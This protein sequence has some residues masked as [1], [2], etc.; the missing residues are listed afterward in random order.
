MKFFRSLFL[1]VGLAALPAC[2]TSEVADAGKPCELTTAIQ[3]QAA[4]PAPVPVA[5]PAP[6]PAA[7]HSFVVHFDFDSA[8]IRASAMQILYEASQVAGKVK[9]TAIRI[10]GFTDA[11]GKSSYNQHLSERRAQAVADQFNK[12]GVK[13]T[14]VETKGFGKANAVTKSKGKSKDNRRVEIVFEGG[15]TAELPADTIKTASADAHAATTTKAY[16]ASVAAVTAPTRDF[17][18]SLPLQ[19]AVKHAIKRDRVQ[20]GTA[21]IPPASAIMGSPSWMGGRAV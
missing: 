7:P 2:A 16:P 9:P 3:A 5:I 18:P 6:A 13:V 1:L 15:D 17:S 11:S 20:I 21:W 4:A 12:L 14:V 19:T 10:H 8:D